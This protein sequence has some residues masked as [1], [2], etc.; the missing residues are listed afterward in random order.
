M[1]LKATSKI[2]FYRRKYLILNLLSDIE[3]S[4]LEKTARM[5]GWTL[6]LVR[7]EYY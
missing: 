7:N 1:G 6:F 4:E 3:A 5:L 2:I